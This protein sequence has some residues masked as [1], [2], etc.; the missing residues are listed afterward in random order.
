MIG[1]RSDQCEVRVA[2]NIDASVLR[3]YAQGL[4]ARATFAIAREQSLDDIVKRFAA[5]AYSVYCSFRLNVY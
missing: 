2:Y 5:F 3:G 1:F 4:F